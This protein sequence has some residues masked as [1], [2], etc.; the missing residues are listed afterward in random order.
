MPAPEMYDQSVPQFG[1]GQLVTG[2]LAKNLL[3]GRNDG[4]YKRGGGGGGGKSKRDY[5]NE[6]Q[7]MRVQAKI[8]DE[9][10]RASSARSVQ[11]NHMNQ[12]NSL[13]NFAQVMT[14]ADADPNAVAA[15]G[16]DGAPGGGGGRATG[17]T[18]LTADDGLET[19]P[20]GRTR[21]LRDP[22]SWLFGRQQPDQVRIVGESIYGNRNIPAGWSRPGQGS[23]SSPGGSFSW[24]YGADGPGVPP[25]T[26]PAG[27]GEPPQTGVPTVGPKPRPQQVPVIPPTGQTEAPAPQAGPM[28][29]PFDP[30]SVMKAP[31]VSGRGGDE[32]KVRVSERKLTPEQRRIALQE[33]NDNFEAKQAEASAAGVGMD[34][35]LQKEIAQDFATQRFPLEDKQLAGLSADQK[36]RNKDK[37]RI[38]PAAAPAAEPAAPS[39]TTT[40]GA[41]GR[42]QP[43]GQSGNVQGSQF[44]GQNTQA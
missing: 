40:Y 33:F 37:I 35:D 7:A 34:D 44:N 29:G 39:N 11:E 10:A 17:Y 22:G 36:R 16:E 4:K 6:E 41:G 25:G 5:Q 18:G 14:A 21:S 42:P 8:A 2:L 38:A 20:G 43:T 32:G 23:V 15:E 9:M 13:A 24:N 31:Y 28:Q 26:P 3:G 19:I 12:M 27:P 1:R 30:T